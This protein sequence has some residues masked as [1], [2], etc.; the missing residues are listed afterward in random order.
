M[1]LSPRRAGVGVGVIVRLSLVE[2]G[3]L[4]G[5]RP[6]GFFQSPELFENLTPLLWGKSR[7]FSE[8][9]GFAH[10]ENATTPTPYRKPRFY[11]GWVVGGLKRSQIADVDGPYAIT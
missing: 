3:F 6:H 11:S 4:A 8:D 9:F 10:W 2:Q 1:N 5:R 7:Q